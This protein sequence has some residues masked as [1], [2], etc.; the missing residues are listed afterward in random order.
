MGKA[1]FPSFPP[2]RDKLKGQPVTKVN[3]ILDDICVDIGYSA[4][5]SLVGWFGGS[6]LVVPPE[7]SE[8]NPIAKAIGYLA[9]RRLAATWG[10]QRLWVPLAHA[11]GVDRRDRRI[12]ALLLSGARIADISARVGVGERRVQQIRFKVKQMGMLEFLAES[13]PRKVRGI[14]QPK[15][16]PVVCDENAL[17][18][19]PWLSARKK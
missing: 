13:P 9:G 18:K 7:I 1:V 15:S 12:V 4:T 2:R 17:T 10:G 11:V 6:Y 3:T 8:Q 5:N 16:D 19:L 14:R